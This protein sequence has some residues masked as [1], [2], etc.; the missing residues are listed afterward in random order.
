MREFPKQSRNGSPVKNSRL[1]TYLWA[2]EKAI[3]DFKEL[4]P[5]KDSM[6]LKEFEGIIDD[7]VDI[8]T[9]RGRF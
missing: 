7:I 5:D 1:R 8:C 6:P 3:G 9:N 2:T 4:H